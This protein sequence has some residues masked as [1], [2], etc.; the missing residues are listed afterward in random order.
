M[1]FQLL[2]WCKSNVQRFVKLLDTWSL[3]LG[4]VFG[5]IGFGY[6][7][8][9]KKQANLVAR[10]SGIA[11]MIFPYFVENKYAALVVGVVLMALPKFIQ[12]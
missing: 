11:L 5:S 2:T 1:C 10:Y 8:Y 3:I 9:G 7:I 6:F 12:L 4:L